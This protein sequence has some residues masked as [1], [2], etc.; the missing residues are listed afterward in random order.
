MCFIPD[1]AVCN[2][3]KDDLVSWGIRNFKSY[4]STLGKG[5]YHFH[6]DIYELLHDIAIPVQCDL[7]SI[8]IYCSHK[9]HNRIS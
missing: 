9:Y 4:S 2:Y 3:V 1:V 5:D 6:F 7:L 8:H